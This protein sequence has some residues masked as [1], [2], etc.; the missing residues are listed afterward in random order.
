MTD[1]VAAPPGPMLRGRRR[2]SAVLEGLLDGARAGR[3]GALV[4]R[5]DAGV[6]KTAL[7]EYVVASAAD[8][9]V[10]RAV[11]V[12]SE[13]ELAFA[14]LHQLCVPV[15]DRLERLPGPQRDALRVTFGLG[16]G[17]V[18]D[19]FLV[20]LAV[21]GLLAEAAEER[22]LVCVVD[23]AQWLDTASAQALAFVARR[24]FAE[25]VVLLFAA[26]QPSDELAGLP[27]LA[28]EGLQEADARELLRS[29]VPGR[30]DER[31]HEQVIAE[32]R[33]NPLALLE[34]TRGLSPAQL[35][36]GFGLPAA[37]SLEGRIQQNF[38][39]RVDALPEGSRRL[40]LVAAA[41][42][43]GDPALVWRAARR[44]GITAAALGPAESAGLLEVGARVRFRHP[45]VRSAVYLPASPR[46][47]RDAHRVLAEA[48]DAAVDPDRR[49]WHLAE[50]AP[51][52]DEQVAAE[53]ERAAGR[54][55]A[56]GGVAAAAAF[57]ERAV[58]LT[59]EPERRAGRALAAARANL[60][61]GAFDAALALLATAEAG[62]GDELEHASV[63]LVRGQ[64]AF[65]SSAG[66]DA[67]A[68][69]L[70]AARQ[71]E[72]LDP[73]L[74]RETYLDAWVAAL[75]A[76]GFARAGNVHEVS[77]VAMSA[78]E[79]ASAPRS[80]DLLLDGFSVLVTEGRVA[81]APMLR[82]AARVFAEEEIAM[83]EGLRWGYAAGWAACELWDEE[84]W[85]AILVR[86]LESV[87]E[88]GLLSVLPIYL[89]A[90]GV[91]ATW[92]GDFATAASL[93]AE[94]DAIAEATG[95]RFARYAAVSLAGFRGAEAEACWLIEVVEKDASAAGQGV[96]I[97]WCQ[98]VSGILYNGL[99]RYEQALASAQR[100]SEQAPEL[101]VSAW[102]LPEL[103]EAA[104]RTGN[105]QLALEALEQLA[106]ATS[107]GATDWALGIH[108]R[109]R[110][111]LGASD[112]AENFY[113]EAIERLGRTRIRFEL[114]RAH[115]VYGE[116]LRR[117]NRRVDSR[118]QLRIAD[119]M[120]TEMGARAFAER[121]KGE[122]LATGQR[123]RKRA[124]ETRDDLT[125][126]EA[127]VAR[128]ARDG[129][130][131]AEIGERLFI[132]RSTVEYHLH[133]VFGKLGISS[134]H[135]L[136]HALPRESSAAAGP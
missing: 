4:V 15:L 13:M 14:A 18:P 132:S 17:P 42:P 118:E 26:R 90:L 45:L 66:A 87:R 100:A 63:D 60:Q 119:Q 121:T 5:G 38:L 56:R 39:A 79:P 133:K 76:G 105:T 58:G 120:F 25:S 93:V 8:L 77:R 50:A 40:L 36:G 16:E 11:G 30:L 135:Q 53:L 98:L 70:K 115:L 68:L 57:L 29:V 102:A 127:Q 55:Q 117:A 110:A 112:V 47:R 88:A 91:R 21:L 20:G 35:A 92:R 82:R 81:A 95:H 136:E 54:A 19:R 32:A 126:Q 10:V 108:A 51:G 65:A 31:V 48:T 44:L 22:A 71:L 9:G 7:L 24:L 23:D 37:L 89:N 122:L 128:L 41:E 73:A 83:D 109:C 123:V 114:A 75:F 6:G 113:R 3:S 97:R 116:W 99:G 111:L 103:I 43:T 59:S 1:G 69:L 131:N 86:Q 106:E 129:V 64:I 12:E 130:S 101:F 27:E 94:G 67:P 2:E 28:V 74:A 33:G 85:Q 125:V 134:R 107:A 34:L 46:E 72:S 96:G 62:P 84:T 49:A 104:T 61:A 78:P 80:T 52:P 124:A